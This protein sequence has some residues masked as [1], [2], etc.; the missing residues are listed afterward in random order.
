ME[1]N[2][3]LS[4]A[5][6]KLKLKHRAF[7]S[8]RLCGVVSN[9]RDR[10][11]FRTVVAYVPLQES[12]PQ[13]DPLDQNFLAC[14][15]GR[16]ICKQAAKGAVHCTWVG[17]RCG[18]QRA[19]RTSMDAGVHPVAVHVPVDVLQLLQQARSP[20]PGSRCSVSFGRRCCVPLSSALEKPSQ[21]CFPRLAAVG[22][23]ADT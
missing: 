2:K 15:G 19:R 9:V 22:I 16:L 7:F 5:I 6:A 1:Q 8:D 21:S 14:K 17:Q 11:Q 3:E 18:E 10:A 20:H 23:A 4:I 13:P 12:R